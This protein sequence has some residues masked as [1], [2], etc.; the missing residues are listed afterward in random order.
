MGF[1]AS[2]VDTSL[3]VYYSKT[4]TLYLLIYVDG[5]LLVEN[6]KNAINYYIMELSRHFSLKDLRPTNFFLDIEFIRHPHG[7]LLSQQQYITDILQRAHMESAKPISSPME[8]NTKLSQYS[9]HPLDDPTKYRNIVGVVQYVA[10]TRLDISFAVSKASQFLQSPTDEHWM[11][12]KR[13]LRYLKHI[14]MHGLNLS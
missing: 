7:I 5:I 8:V 2:M 10:I 12:V 6:S 1:W 13:I 3:F 4:I 14:V 11:V 9:G